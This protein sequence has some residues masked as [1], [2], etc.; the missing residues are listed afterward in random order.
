MQRE[1]IKP[2][3][4]TFLGVLSACNH[5]GLIEEGRRYFKQMS[6]QF[7]LQ[8][9]EKH[10]ACMVDLF[11]RAGC[12]QEAHNLINSMPM[13]PTSVVWGALLAA[14]RVH[15]NVQLAEVAAAELFKIEPDNSGNYIL[16]SNIYATAG[17][18]RDVA[19]VRPMIRE[20]RVRKNR[21]SSWIKLGSI[22]YEFVMGD[23]S[24][25]DVD[26]TYSILNLLQEDMKLA[27][28]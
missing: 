28:T 21:G 19:F 2:D 9:T 6:E 14:C 10:Y 8:P 15:C 3:V 4:V 12:L 16:L 27:D 5:G 1:N 17:Q 7:E 13:T 11:G 23:I 25:M 24:H 20:H 22:V 18:W 26:E